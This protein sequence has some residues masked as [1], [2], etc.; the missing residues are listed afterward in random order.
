M[1]KTNKK[2]HI[3]VP[4]VF[5]IPC[6]VLPCCRNKNESMQIV[7]LLLSLLLLLEQ[8]V[9]V[10]IPAVNN[11]YTYS[12]Y[13]QEHWFKN[14]II[15]FFFPPPS[16]PPTVFFIS[17]Y[18]ILYNV[19]VTFTWSFF[20]FNFDFGLIPKLLLLLCLVLSSVCL[21]I[22]NNKESFPGAVVHSVLLVSVSVHSR[23]VTNYW[24][25]L[26]CP[27]CCRAEV[28]TLLQPLI[29]AGSFN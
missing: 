3:Y 21:F 12:L 25:L 20:C 18:S 23:R 24:N 28:A 1:G 11:H 5:C 10:P 22:Q 27:E 8:V 17:F 13:W 14:G 4:T 6:W 7:L 29:C 16:L 26:F 19:P 9:A 2:H 15:W